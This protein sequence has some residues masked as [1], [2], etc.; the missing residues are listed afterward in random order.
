MQRLTGYLTA[1]GRFLLRLAGKSL[2]FFKAL[3]RKEFASLKEHLSTLP[4]LISPLSR[5][6]LFIYQSVSEY[7]LSAILEAEREGKQH[8][9]YFI[10]HA[11]RDAK[12]KYSEVENMVFALI[13]ASRKLK[14]YLQAHQIKV[15]TRQPLRKV[16]ER[17][18]HSS[19]MTDWVDQLADF[20]LEYVP[21]RAIKAQALPDLITECT[22]PPP[23]GEKEESELLVD[24]SSTK[25][26][27]WSQAV[28]KPP[29]GD[30][31]EY[32]IKFEFLGS[33]NEVEYEALISGLQLCIMAG[34][35]SA[36]SVTH[37]SQWVRSQA[38]TKPKKII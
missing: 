34:Q 21:G 18:V 5:E 11:L 7:A 37:N 22:T 30:K 1:L 19:R 23:V 15:L 17:R 3:K 14:P 26:M 25:S 8:S 20:G 33:N 31:M 2:S 36:P 12:A 6:A 4:K 13:M 28:L 38:S 29:V 9:V 27:M 16:I 32:A 10:S 24:G 35:Q